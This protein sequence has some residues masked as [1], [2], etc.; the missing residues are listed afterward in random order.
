MGNTIIARNPQ[1]PIYSIEGVEN[2]GIMEKIRG[3]YV[4]PAEF[5]ANGYQHLGPIATYGE[6]EIFKDLDQWAPSAGDYDSRLLQINPRLLASDRTR[7]LLSLI[8][9]DAAVHKILSEN[10]FVDVLKT[11]DVA[12]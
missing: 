9:A 8:A 11:P 4:M 3:V 10:P 6:S 7:E 5:V 2:R 1:K 12:D